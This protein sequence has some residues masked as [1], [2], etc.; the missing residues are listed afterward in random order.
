M[1]INGDNDVIGQYWWNLLDST[2][3]GEKTEYSGSVHRLFVG[4]IRH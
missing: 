3:V 4:F 2:N 1:I